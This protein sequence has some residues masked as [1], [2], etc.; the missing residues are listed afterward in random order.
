MNEDETPNELIVHA[1][2]LTGYLSGSIG[3]TPIT[4]EYADMIS[5][6]IAGLKDF[7]ATFTGRWVTDRYYDMEGTW[8]VDGEQP[9]TDCIEPDEITD[10]D[11]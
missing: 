5:N 1:V 11:D 7:S 3:T 10:N 4:D 9:I 2:D 6:R 8:T